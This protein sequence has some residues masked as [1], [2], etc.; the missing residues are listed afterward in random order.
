M[1]YKQKVLSSQIHSYTCASKV[2]NTHSHIVTC[3]VEENWKKKK[4][5]EEKGTKENFT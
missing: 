4:E 3:N 1:Y 5:K 2:V